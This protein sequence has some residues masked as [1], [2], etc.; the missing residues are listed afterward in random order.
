MEMETKEYVLE[1][2]ASEMVAGASSPPRQPR[3]L[4]W[5]I[6]ETIIN[7]LDV[8]LTPPSNRGR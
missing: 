4:P 3:Q 1:V 2:S 6:F 8:T 5:L 7:Y